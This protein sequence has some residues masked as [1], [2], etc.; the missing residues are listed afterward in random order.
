MAAVAV[1]GAV[2]GAAC[3]QA[4]PERLMR[5]YLGDPPG[6]GCSLFMICA[7][8][9]NLPAR[10]ANLPFD[11]R[12]E[13]APVAPLATGTLGLA[14]HPG[15]AAQRVRELVVLAQAMGIKPE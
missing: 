10:R 11:L 2:S 13:L 1:L 4:W 15:V 6:A 3:A 12:R 5:L 8:D 7:A 9:T 14:S